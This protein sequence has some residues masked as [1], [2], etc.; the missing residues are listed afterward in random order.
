MGDSA[1]WEFQFSPASI[2]FGN[3]ATLTKRECFSHPSLRAIITRV[4]QRED[5]P[6]GLITCVLADG[7]SLRRGAVCPPRCAT[8]ALSLCTNKEAVAFEDS[9]RGTFKD[10]Y[11]SPYKIAT[12]PHVPWEYKNTLL[13][14]GILNK[15]I[16]VLK[17]KMDA[18][19]YE[20][21]QS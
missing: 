17:L 1:A 9:E 8:V 6:E 11:F 20:P 16:E 14:P 21:C 15:V 3:D 13:P 2:F 18:G 4:E 10:L 5:L 7:L 19:V 12:V